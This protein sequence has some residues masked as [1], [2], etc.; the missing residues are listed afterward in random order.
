MERLAS[1]KNSISFRIQN[2]V[3]M[4]MQW[5]FMAANAA[6][7]GDAAKKLA[8]SIVTLGRGLFSKARIKI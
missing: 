1:Y 8:V 6:H 5:F 4:D 2:F 3:R 7:A